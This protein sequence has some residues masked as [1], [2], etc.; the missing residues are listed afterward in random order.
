MHCLRV[1]MWYFGNWWLPMQ[2]I[3]FSVWSYTNLTLKKYE[4]FDSDGYKFKFPCPM[5]VEW[6]M[7]NNTKKQNAAKPPECN[8]IIHLVCKKRVHKIF[9][10]KRKQNLKK[11]T[12]SMCIFMTYSSM[13]CA[14]LPAFM[15]VSRAPFHLVLFS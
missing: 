13:F 3:L 5:I 6:H 12:V 1:K 10:G 8:F 9:A 2:L 7:H 14:C 11:Q 15:P 4:R